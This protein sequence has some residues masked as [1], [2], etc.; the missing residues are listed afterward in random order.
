M[1]LGQAPP[2]WNCVSTIRLE[3]SPRLR[4]CPPRTCPGLFR[5]GRLR[6]ERPRQGVLPALHWLIS[7]LPPSTSCHGQVPDFAI[8][9]SFPAVLPLPQETSLNLPPLLPSASCASPSLSKT[10]GQ[11]FA[12]CSVSGIL[13]PVPVLLLP[14]GKAHFSSELPS[15][16]PEC[17]EVP[18]HR[19]LLGFLGPAAMGIQSPSLSSTRARG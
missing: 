18:R 12:I 14:W 19:P 9:L 8:S 4:T 17:L 7:Q 6:E 10:S 11:I 15:P 13:G 1:S 16:P 5:R 3:P 2:G